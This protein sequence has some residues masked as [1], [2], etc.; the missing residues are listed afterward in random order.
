[1]GDDAEDLR[2]HVDAVDAVDVEPI[3]KG[4]RR[5][6]AGFLMSDRSDAAVEK[7]RRGGLAEIV[8]HGAE[9]DDHLLGTTEWRDGLARPVDDHERVDPDVPFGV[10]LRLLLTIDQR[11]HFRPQ[12]LHDA[13]LASER[14]PDRRPFG[15]QQQLLELTPDAL[16]GEIVERD[17]GADRLRLFR[18]RELEPRGE[19]QRAQHAEAVIGERLRVDHPQH[20]A[21]EIGASLERIDVLAGKR[22]PG[23]RVD[24]EVTAPC[25]LAY[26]HRGI[27]GNGEPGVAAADLRL[28]PRERDV[29]TGD[30]VHGKTPPD[31]F[32]AAE[33]RQHGRQVV[34]G[35][36]VD[37]EVQILGR[38][39]PQAIA[40]PA[41]DDER[42]PA[43]RLRRRRD[44]ACERQ[45][46]IACLV[47]I[48]IRHATVKGQRATVNG[49]CS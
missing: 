47:W 33:G 18:D 29:D 48:G 1:M 43:A 27:A 3:E 19:L 44:C 41:A 25:G 6:D 32:H 31:R 9:H 42:A 49:Q 2:A 17:R 40:D 16:R 37:F 7:R 5:R 8:T 46:V 22:V 35:D 26:R 34:F 28:A 21:P 20:A 36:T 24:R 10:P 4:R 14:E 15:L 13:Q 45:G 23:D 11:R 38:A 39:A 12:P 30:L